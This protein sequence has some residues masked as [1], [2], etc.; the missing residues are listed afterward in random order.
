MPSLVSDSKA[1]IAVYRTAERNW[2]WLNSSNGSF[3]AV[4][5]GAPG[6]LPSPLSF[7]PK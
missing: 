1:N 4:N 6:D 5:F 3:S 2:Y 7:Q